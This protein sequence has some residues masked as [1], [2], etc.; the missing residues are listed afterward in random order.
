MLTVF[1]TWKSAMDKAY[2]LLQLFQS[3]QQFF[4]VLKVDKVYEEAYFLFLETKL[5]SSNKSLGVILPRTARGPSC[6]VSLSP[7]D[8]SH[9]TLRFVV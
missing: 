3:K 9:T 2:T 8:G 5:C 1:S 7:A 6:N 4:G